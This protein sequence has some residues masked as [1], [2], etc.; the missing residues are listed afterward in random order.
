VI[1][2]EMLQRFWRRGQAQELPQ[3]VAQDTTRLG[4]AAKRLLDDPVLQL[5]FDMLEDDFIERWKDT[6]LGEGDAR[7]EWY[8]M[9]YALTELQAKLRGLLDNAQILEEEEARRAA[10]PDLWAA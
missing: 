1:A 5:A 6:P 10:N 4:Y 8:R 2:K 7:E 3:A 9:L